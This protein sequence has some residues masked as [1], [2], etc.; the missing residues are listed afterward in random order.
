MCWATLAALGV[1]LILH[2]M[3]GGITLFIHDL[4]AILPL[5][6]HVAE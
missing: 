2:L 1:Y 3:L 6:W 4:K 5:H